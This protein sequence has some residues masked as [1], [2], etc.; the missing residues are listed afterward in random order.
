MIHRL[1]K[2]L[3]P[4][5]QPLLKWYLRKTRRFHY[6][7]L[8][9]VVHP[10]CFYPGF[11][12]S[13]KFL[14]DHLNQMDLAGKKFLELGA[15]CGIISLLAARKKAIV[16]A[17]DINPVAIR[18]IRENALLNKFA[19]EVIQS[20][21]F[22]D[23]PDKSFDV[24]IITPP[25]Y[26][27]DPVDI[28]E[29]AW[30]CGKNFEFFENLFPQLAKRFSGLSEILMNLSEDCDIDRIR[31]IARKSG[32]GLTLINKEKRMDEWNFIFRIGRNISG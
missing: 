30:F 22:N 3:T 15:G 29:M 4:V 32:L 5:L 1:L 9:A 20:D 8:T 28:N 26:P 11:I 12:L 18:C 2:I 21:L 6:K 10:G 23:I 14:L 17:S 7:G 19:L 25:Y 13:T 16:T 24:V 31:N 27:K